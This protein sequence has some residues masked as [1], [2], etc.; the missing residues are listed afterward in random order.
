MA[1][2]IRKDNFAEKVLR[3]EL[4]VLVDFYSDSCV[5]CKQISPLIGELEDDYEGKL[6]VYKV[7]VNFEE[8]LAAD[9]SVMGVPTLL[10]FRNGEKKGKKT[11]VISRSD[12]REWIRGYVE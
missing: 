12:L 8:E 5:P 3:S 2:R 11:G 10:V 7:N 4:P 9:Y 1:E 6:A